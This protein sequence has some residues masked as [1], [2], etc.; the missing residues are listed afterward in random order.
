MS[1]YDFSALSKVRGESRVARLSEDLKLEKEGGRDRD[2]YNIDMIPLARTRLKV[3]SEADDE[4]IP[5]GFVE[6]DIDAYLPLFGFVDGTVT[7]YDRDRRMYEH[8]EFTSYLWGLFQ[9]HREQV[10]TMVG[11]REKKTGRLLWVFGW[12]SSP[13]YVDLASQV[14]IE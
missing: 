2:L 3:F 6:A 1:N 8:H 10:D 12:R 4:G 13:K 11:L 14:S 5:D 9:L 7:R